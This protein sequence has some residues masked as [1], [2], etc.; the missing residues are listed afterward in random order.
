VLAKTLRDDQIEVIGKLRDEL[1]HGVRRIVVGAPTGFGKGVVIADLTDRARHKQKKI[2]ITVPRLM[3]VDQTVEMIAAQGAEGDIGVIQATHWMT[4]SSKTVQIASVQTLRNLWNKGQMPAVDLVLIDE[5]HIW[6]E[7]FGKWLCDPKWQNIPIIGF[8]A[9]PW[10]K[11]LGAY[12][13]RLITGNTIDNLIGAGTLVPFRT[14]A[15][16]MPDLSHVSVSLGDFVESELDAVMR[17]KKLV[18]NIVET[19]KRLADGRPTVCFC[20]SRAHADQ[21]AIEFAEVGIGSAYVDCDTPDWERKQAREQMLAGEVKVVTNV[22]IIGLGVDWPEVSCIIYARPTMSDVRF[23]QNI[24]RGLRACEGKKD[25][26]ILDHSTTTARLGFVNEIYALHNKLEDGKSKPKAVGIALPKPCPQCFYLKPPRVAVCPNC[27]FKVEA[28]A[29]PVL[30]ERGTLREYKPGDEMDVYSKLVRARLDRDHVWGQL[31]WW[32]KHMGYKPGWVHMKFRE[33]FDVMFPRDLYWEDK[34]NHPAPE[35]LK[36]LVKSADRYRNERRRE[37]YAERKVDDHNKRAMT[38][39]EQ[40]II[41]EVAM[42]YRPKY[43]EGTL[44]TEQDL[45]DMD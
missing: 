27:G 12:Y 37:R 36:F 33:I 15:P 13:S 34:V 21:V 31:V 42:R 29:T 39:R 40:A 28:H 1:E 9:T 5:V 45:E 30:C 7:Y 32:Q 8:S 43:V 11:P 44:L 41:D 6:F 26:L 3:L 25:L 19:W 16:D 18:A 2:L 38:E 24:G 14:F 20:C 22:D 4:D 23:V 35:L 10:N 17:P